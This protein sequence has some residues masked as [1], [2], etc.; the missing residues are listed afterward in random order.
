M[1]GCRVSRTHE[2]NEQPFRLPA[3]RL[4][5]PGVS[6]EDSLQPPA[7]DVQP[8]GLNT[9]ELKLAAFGLL[10]IGSATIAF[11]AGA[12]VPSDRDWWRARGR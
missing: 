4:V 6:L 12:K 8:F 5:Q 1:D 10:R 2:S 11:D 9:L 7:T 3:T